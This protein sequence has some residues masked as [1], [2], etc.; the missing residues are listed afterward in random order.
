V[1]NIY[2]KRITTMGAFILMIY[3]GIF[4]HK[5]L[6]DMSLWLGIPIILLWLFTYDLVSYKD[7]ASR[8]EVSSHA[9]S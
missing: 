3:L 8:K 9:K 7:K 1:N 4:A 2:M 5:T 6:G